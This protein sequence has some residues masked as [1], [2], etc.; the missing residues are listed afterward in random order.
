MTL[1]RQLIKEGLFSDTIVGV[2][3]PER[4]TE[5]R[6]VPF[7]VARKMIVA[8][9]Y[10][11]T[12]RA[13]QKATLGVYYHKEMLGAIA[14]GLG[15][16]PDTQRGNEAIEF[17]RLWLSDLMPKYSET[18]VIGALHTYIRETMPEISRVWT[19]A[20]LGENNPGTIYK[21]ANYKYL[22]SVTG[23]FWI[24]PEGDKIHDRTL[25]ALQ[26]KS[27]PKPKLLD[28]NPR[29]WGEGKESVPF[30]MEWRYANG[31]EKTTAKLLLFEYDL[32]PSKK[33][34]RKRHRLLSSH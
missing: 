24:S 19:W 2:S 17:E 1:T 33:L 25:Y 4:H 20:D 7:K 26:T 9:H 3:V 34:K 6:E 30:T 32:Y 8:N 22:R 21:A 28:K 10:S 12:L 31:W 15:L 13:C 5:I 16:N 11:G 27:N 14:I 23:H 18:V 29:L